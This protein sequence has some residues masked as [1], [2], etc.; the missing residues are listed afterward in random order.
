MIQGALVD[1]V[2]SA[3]LWTEWPVQDACVSAYS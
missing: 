1:W 3:V 2:S